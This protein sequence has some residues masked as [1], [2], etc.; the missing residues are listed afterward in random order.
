M[1]IKKIYYALPIV[2]LAI[3]IV[4][5]VEAKAVNSLTMDVNPSIEIQTNRLDR[6]VAI[7]P[8]NKD[9]RQLLKDFKAQDK[10][11][12]NTVNDLVDLMI[13]S[14]HIK[15]GADNFVMISVE[16]DS[17]ESKY[18]DKVNKAISAM[19]E[20]KRIEATVLNQSITKDEKMSNK[21]GAQIAAERLYQIDKNLNLTELGDMTVRELFNYSK[22]NNI[23]IENLFKIA[24][25]NKEKA[26]VNSSKT[27]ISKEKAGEIAL[28]VI[29]GKILK[30][31]LDDLD[32]DDG[33][34]YEVEILSENGKYEIEI[35]AYSG[36]VKKYEKD[37]DQD[38]DDKYN[39][40]KDNDKKDYNKKAP[41]KQV[42]KQDNTI[43]TPD[44][45]KK[46]AMDKVGGGRITD[47]ELDDDEYE[48]EIKKDGLEYELEIDAYT[49]K[50]LD[51]DV[52][53]DDDDDDDDDYDDHD[54]ND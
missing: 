2:I 43:I 8:L 51:F 18:V 14:G 16:D 13:L 39:T 7:K 44:Q 49:G 36:K 40:D 20:N 21:T 48:I 29:N 31:E 23:P 38:D 17:M 3:L 19:L 1:K 4:G 53:Y 45:A 52:D 47:F 28:G 46:I 33:P 12:E 15:G 27:I 50:I 35:H 54:D 9:A 25:E 34:E 37:D 6:V 24:A 10:N 41:V 32:D 26:K 22:A 42:K 30:I 5:F 11:L